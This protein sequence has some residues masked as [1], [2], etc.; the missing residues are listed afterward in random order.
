M[1][2]FHDYSVFPANLMKSE[3]FYI[4]QE[5]ILESSILIFEVK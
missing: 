5:T 4:L 3:G 2:V 1:S